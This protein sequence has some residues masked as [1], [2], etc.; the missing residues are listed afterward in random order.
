MHDT[1]TITLPPRS[2]GRRPA[3]VDNPGRLLII[4]A[5]GSGKTRFSDRMA[6]DLGNQAFCISPI[7]ALYGTAAADE[8]R[9]GID[10][11]YAAMRQTSPLL[12]PEG[13]PVPPSQLEKLM[14]LLLSEEVANLIRYKVVHASD[15]DT[16]MEPT[17]LDMVIERWKEMFP[18]NDVLI[19]GGKLLFSRTADSDARRR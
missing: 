13:S 2:D 7:A 19:E 10:T 8:S 11:V 14:A 18:D 9:Q 3:T 12:M 4:G 6:A 16:V 17:R 5:N 1:P 15:P